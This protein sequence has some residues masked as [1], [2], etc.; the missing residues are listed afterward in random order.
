L[1]LITGGGSGV[2]LA[3]ARM[4]AARGADLIL[5]D[6]N[7]AALS[8][9]G[10]ELGAFTAFC[11]VTA[12]SSVAIFVADLHHRFSPVDV[13]INAAGDGYVRALGMMRVTLALLPAMRRERTPKL[14]FNV[15]PD[16]EPGGEAEPLF[17]NV[18]SPRHFRRLSA[19]LAIQARGSAV[20]VATVMP[21]RAVGDSVGAAVGTRCDEGDVVAAIQAAVFG[22]ARHTHR[23]RHPGQSRRA[24]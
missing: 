17:P 18:A 23:P 19:S 12:E 20:R 14:V 7:G 24:G 15:A 1:V 3:C 9:V 22:N 4:F 11:D 10:E 6:S 2:G 5:C 16:F 13:L 8:Q 21:R